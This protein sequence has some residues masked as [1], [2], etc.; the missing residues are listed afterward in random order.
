MGDKKE[1]YSIQ[2]ISELDWILMYYIFPS[3]IQF[4]FS[5]IVII[6]TF[7][8]PIYSNVETFHLLAFAFAFPF[9]LGD[10]PRLRWS[11]GERF[12]E[13]QSVIELQFSFSGDGDDPPPVA[14][15][16]RDG[17]KRI[18]ASKCR[19]L[20]KLSINTH[21]KKTCSIFSSI[22]ILTVFYV[23]FENKRRYLPNWNIAF[24]T[25]IWTSK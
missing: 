23:E 25:V 1:T 20:L 15:F 3:V 19:N 7:G 21:K 14:E 10:V 2:V 13:R 4:H 9:G 12:G 16:L 6:S 17:V 24:W 11:T 8:W 5:F 18:V 22:Q